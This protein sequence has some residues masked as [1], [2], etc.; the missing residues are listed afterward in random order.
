MIVISIPPQLSR[1]ARSVV[2][3]SAWQSTKTNSWKAEGFDVVSLKAKG[4]SGV[5]EPCTSMVDI[6]ELR[7]GHPRPWTADFLEKLQKRAEKW[8]AS[9]I[10]IEPVDLGTQLAERVI[11][12]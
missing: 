8:P 11:C 3:G 4:E 7:A 12:C 1:L 2:F 5:L 10:P 9:P 6:V